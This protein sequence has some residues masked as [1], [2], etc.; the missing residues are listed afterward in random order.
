MARISPGFGHPLGILV[1]SGSCGYRKLECRANKEE[2]FRDRPA[3]HRETGGFVAP[4][5]GG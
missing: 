3:L 1:N 4:K 5:G 2:D